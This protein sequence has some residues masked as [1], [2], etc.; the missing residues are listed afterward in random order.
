MVYNIQKKEDIND[1]CTTGNKTSATDPHHFS[2]GPACP[3]YADPDI[4]F[5]FDADPDP[6]FQMKAQNL[7]KAQIGSYSPPFVLSSAN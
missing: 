5:H 6:S 1:S 3:F 4:T 2:S 7:E